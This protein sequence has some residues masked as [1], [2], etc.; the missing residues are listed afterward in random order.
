M[1]GEAHQHLPCRQVRNQLAARR[2][3]GISRDQGEGSMGLLGVLP[4]A[5]RVA[6]HQ[7][8]DAVWH[9]PGEA[10]VGV[11]AQGEEQREQDAAGP[12][13]PEAP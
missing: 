4:L 7:R 1:V 3:A 2:H 5:R 9:Q 12:H 6:V 10:A 11:A 13:P 8:L